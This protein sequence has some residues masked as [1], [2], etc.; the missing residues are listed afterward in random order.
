MCRIILQSF[1]LL[2]IRNNVT[3]VIH[4]EKVGNCILNGFVGTLTQK[5]SINQN[6]YTNSFVD[7]DV[8]DADLNVRFYYSIYCKLSIEKRGHFLTISNVISID[9]CISTRLC[10]AWLIDVCM[11]EKCKMWHILCDMTCMWCTY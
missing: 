9:A 5:K 8:V 1:P 6:A 2:S 11:Y 7:D 10:L 4:F 3:H